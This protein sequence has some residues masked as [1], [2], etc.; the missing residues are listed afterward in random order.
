MEIPSPPSSRGPGCRIL[1]PDTR[2][3]IPL[4]VVGFN[5]FRLPETSV[6]SLAMPR[7]TIFALL[8]IGSFCAMAVAADP[9]RVEQVTVTSIESGDDFGFEKGGKRTLAYLRGID[10][11]D[12]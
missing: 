12:K 8:A 10:A 3:R 11:P 2:V 6:W 5:L 1:S 7:R 9:I 4:G